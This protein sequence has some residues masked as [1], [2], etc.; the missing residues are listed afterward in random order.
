ME[1]E[2][3]SYTRSNQVDFHLPFI[4]CTDL[5]HLQV[6]AEIEVTREDEKEQDSK[7]AETV[8]NTKEH[9]PILISYQ[10]C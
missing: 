7:Q 3:H 4:L 9:Y 2:L 1:V 10:Y 8:H 6:D 5:K